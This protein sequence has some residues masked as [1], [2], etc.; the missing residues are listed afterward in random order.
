M[1]LAGAR[2]KTAATVQ[3][4]PARKITARAFAQALAEAGVLTSLDGVRRIVIVA[5]PDALSPVMLHVERA[6]DE[7]LLDVAALLAGTE[8]A[9]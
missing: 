8:E 2:V 7:R 5:G 6:G 9:L 4:A 1:A 3:A